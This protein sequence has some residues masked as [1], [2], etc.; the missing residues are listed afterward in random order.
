MKRVPVIFAIDKKVIVPCGVTITSL[1]LNAGA[2]TFYDLF[3]LCDGMQLG[4]DDQKALANAF[5]DWPICSLTFIDVG[6]AFKETEGM[7]SGHI[8][9][10]TYY[11]LEIPSLFPQYDKVLYA[12]IDIIFQQDLVNLYESSL[13]NDELIAAVPD[14]SI[15]G[16]FQ[17][18][19]PLPAKVGKSEKDYFNAGFLVMNLKRMRNEG[20]VDLFREHAKIQYDQ[21]DQDILNIVCGGSVQILPSLY[22]FQVNHFSNYMWNRKAPEL[23]FGE[24]FKKATLHYTWKHKPWNSLECVAYDTW[25]HYYKMSPFYDDGFY[26][27]RQR[28]QIEASRNDYHNRTN[29]QLFLR[30]LVNIKHRLVKK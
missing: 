17:F 6:D 24:L 7:T 2:D 14:L 26:F 18:R 9:K 10:A 20:I 1:L 15:D 11:R 23:R 8:T 29:K 16:R 13:P 5:A 19:S 3:I 21:N 28:A 22:N 25:W 4:L 27:Q 30:I 12:D